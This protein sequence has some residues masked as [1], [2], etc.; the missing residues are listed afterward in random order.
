MKKILALLAILTVS[1]PF[2]S[3]VSGCNSNTKIAIP[4]YL[5][6]TSPPIPKFDPWNLSTWSFIQKNIIIQDYLSGAKNE[7]SSGSSKTWWD[8]NYVPPDPIYISSEDQVLQKALNTINP[9]N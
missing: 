6:K 2:A 3:I 5:I 7:Y 4:E 9:W 1:T 8:W